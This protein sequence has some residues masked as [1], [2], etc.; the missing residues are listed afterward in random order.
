MIMP[1]KDSS[2]EPSTVD[3]NSVSVLIPK[4]KQGDREARQQLLEQIQSYLET[5]ANQRMDGTLKQKIGTSD[6]VQLSFLRVIE[7]FG[8]FR[9]TTAAEFHGWLKTIV[10]NEI[11]N[12]RRTYRAQKRDMARE[13]NVADHPYPDANLTPSSEAMQAERVELFHKILSELSDEH[14]EV[15]RLRNIQQ[16]PFKEIGEKM[17]R[18]EDAVSKLWQRAMLKFE[19]RLSNNGNF[20]S[21]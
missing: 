21:G 19:E 10:T 15:I 5:V 8:D 16:L 17:N 18:S 7:S 14:A 2:P 1:D 4:S 9:G 3:L 6:I 12:T 20:K 13:K 11:H